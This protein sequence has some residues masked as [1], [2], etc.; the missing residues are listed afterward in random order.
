LAGVGHF[1]PREQPA[2]VV[3]RIMSFVARHL[4]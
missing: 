1:P 4:S 2:E 3:Q